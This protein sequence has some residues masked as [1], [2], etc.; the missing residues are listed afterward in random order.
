MKINRRDFMQAIAATVLT[1][2]GGCKLVGDK[3]KPMNIILITFDDLGYNDLSCYGSK[4]IYTPN[5]DKLASEG[6]KFERFYS[7]SPVCTPA[8]GCLLTGRRPESIGLDMP[9]MGS[10]G[11]ASSFKTLPEY[12]LRYDYNT[13]SIGKWHL[14]YD[15]DT[16]PNSQGFEYFF[17][18]RGGKIDYYKYTD[19]AQKVEGV[20]TGKKD[21]YENG[22]PVSI[23]GYSTDVFTDKAIKY[24]T[25]KS[26]Q[27]FLLNLAYNAPHY[28]QRGVLQA[29]ENY[30]AKVAKDLN[31]PTAREIYAAMVMCLDD[32][33]A[34]IIAHL[35]KLGIYDNTAIFIISDNGGDPQH[36]ASNYPLSGG[37]WTLREGGL[38]VPMIMRWPDS[39]AGLKTDTTVYMGDITPT[40]LRK[41]NIDVPDADFDGED[42]YRLI[43]DC[44]YAKERSLYFSYKYNKSLGYQYAIIEG[45]WKLMKVGEKYYLFDLTNDCSETTNLVE[46]QPEIFFQLK[47]KLELEYNLI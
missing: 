13:A 25:E 22:T 16:L 39:H 28:S 37:K 5:I 1:A 41:L 11:M 29:P 38:R 15:G 44:R 34:K 45:D 21:L 24:I 33:V 46:I 10:G 40:I 47:K 32:S 9:L 17:G 7:S 35:D 43:E 3:T 4:D 14:G 27:P 30:I 2:M 20:S 23:E 26:N 6:M 42:I 18:H 36:G 8:R 31:N 19:D 12:L